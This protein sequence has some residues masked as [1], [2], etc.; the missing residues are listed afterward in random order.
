MLVTVALATMLA[1]LNSTMIA[2]ALP[3]LME[4]FG[5][6]LAT[7]G[8]LVTSYLIAMACLQPV[9]GKL[10]DRL[11]R[12]LPILGG[13]V[14]FALA[15][16]AAAF[17]TSLSWLLFFRVQQAIAGAIA[18]P[19]GAA[20][21]RE[22]VPAARRA[23][24]F[25]LVGAA[26][27]LAAAAG[28]PLGGLLVE[29]AGWRAI[30]YVNLILVVPALLIGWRA[31]PARPAGPS[32]SGFDLGGAA[33]LLAVLAG[34][35]GLLT[36]GHH[37]GTLLL[38]SLGGAGLVV[39]A[40]FFFWHELRHPDPVL[41]PRLFQHRTFAA[42]NAAIALSNLAMYS[43]LLAVPI[44]LAGQEGW[45]SA[46]IGLVLTSMSATMV[47]CSPLGGRLSDRWG[48]RWPTVAGLALLTV[49]LLLL[50]LAGRGPVL[51][52]LVGGL[53]VAGIGLGL[54][55]AGMQSAAVEAVPKNE[56][57]VASGL[58]STSRYLGSIVGS[59]V[60]PLLYHPEAG[61]EGFAPV[62]LMVVGAAFFSVVASMGLHH[63][64]PAE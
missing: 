4:E 45:S 9:A 55:S 11:G 53:G 13:L 39:L 60:L 22:V 34:T 26:V 27:G 32:A 23:A 59:S 17:A 6:D 54:S 33:L 43:T 15:S 58:F 62:L 61:V 10:G 8:W 49:G 12:R 52:V 20:L 16:L 44:L 35:A 36:Q 63:W 41:Q 47:I 42:A 48:R 37:L 29:V 56:A 18:L 64:P 57:G 38:Q 19:N 25:G 1:P 50:G 51:P 14:Y 40:L 31:L 5:A 3:R 21:V 2:V 7:S 28:P 46:R 30:F 24:R